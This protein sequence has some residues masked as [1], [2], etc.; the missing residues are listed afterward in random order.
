MESQVNVM[1]GGEAG[2][3]VQSV[4]F[5][6]AKTFAGGYHVFADQDYESRVGEG[7]I[8]TGS[9]PITRQ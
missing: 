1:V 6:L 3:G 2:Q 9:G 8:S 4:G 5:I 7:T